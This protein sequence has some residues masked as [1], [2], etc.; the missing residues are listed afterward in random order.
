MKKIVYLF[1]M[2]CMH[3]FLVAQSD[4][5]S[6]SI[7]QQAIDAAGGK[8]K[9]M[10]IKTMTRKME[11]NMPFGTSESE[12]YYKNGKYYTKSTMGGNVVMEQKYD[13]T[14]FSMNGM[15]GAQIVDDEKMVK[16]MSAQGKPFPVLDLQNEEITLKHDGTS[17][18]SGIECDK[19]LS[20]DL[21][22]NE[23]TLFFD[24][25]THY[26]A[27]L[28]SKNEMQGTMVETTIDFKDYK[29]VDGLLF[30]HTMNLNTGQF[31]MEM[32]TTEIKLN[33]DI[34]DSIFIID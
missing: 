6:T 21:D 5:K 23:T 19:I 15:Q 18:I 12:S 8:D 10:A 20:K 14:R 3:H 2:I 11:I 27:R 31:Q 22:G 34:K 17:K 33:A 9:M 1:V 32:K 26:L 29:M 16:R 30:P 24:L 13:G 25:K 4:A 28:I 7:V